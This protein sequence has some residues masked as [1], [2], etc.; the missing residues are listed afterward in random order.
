[1]TILHARKAAKKSFLHRIVTNDE[2]WI[3]YDNP[4][5]K[6]TTLPNIHD[7]NSLYLGFLKPDETINGKRY[8]QQ[9]IKLKQFITEK[10][11]KFATTRDTITFDH[12]NSRPHVARLVKNYLQNSS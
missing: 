11:L 9:L 1:M 7:V 3:H 5:R 12:V 8:R 6:L 2:K 10:R 4:K